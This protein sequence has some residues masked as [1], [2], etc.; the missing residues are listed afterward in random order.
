MRDSLADLRFAQEILGYKPIVPFEEG[1]GSPSSGIGAGR[2]RRDDRSKIA[3]E[4]GE[5]L[6]GRIFH[7]Q[8]VS[9]FE[10]RM[11]IARPNTPPLAGDL[12]REDIE[13]GRG[14]KVALLL[15]ATTARWL[16]SWRRRDPQ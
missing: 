9:G 16:A 8:R 7:R 6:A 10:Y 14:E 15:L 2:R 12:P 4:P 1:S 11:A 5:D 3:V 13:R